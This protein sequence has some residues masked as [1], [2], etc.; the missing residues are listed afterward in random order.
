[1]RKITQDA[2]IAFRNGFNFGRDNTRVVVEDGESHLYLHGNKI[3]KLTREGE[4]LITT[5]RWNTVTTR[6]RLNG[7]P[8]VK[9]YQQRGKLFLNNEEWDGDWISV[10]HY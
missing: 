8:L 10:G 1:M 3:A 6:E 9:V 7:L 5:A 2:V 4:V